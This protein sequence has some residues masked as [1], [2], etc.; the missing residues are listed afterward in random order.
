MC[1]MKP[2]YLLTVMIK[3]TRCHVVQETSNNTDLLSEPPEEKLY[4][5]IML[6]F[7]SYSFDFT[8]LIFVALPFFFKFVIDETNVYVT[9]IEPSDF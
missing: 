2:D 8:K 5:L 4:I 1:D 6:L 3:L 7:K 9:V